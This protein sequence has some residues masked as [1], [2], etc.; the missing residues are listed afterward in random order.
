VRRISM[1]GG[2]VRGKLWNEIKAAVL[3][4]KLIVPRVVEAASLGAAILAAVGSST[5]TSFTRAIES[6]VHIAEVYEPALELH[7]RYVELWKRYEYVYEV[8][9]RAFNAV[10]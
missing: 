4:M 6:M 5:F 10:W 8:L 9:E 2:E 1:T 7:E 3:G